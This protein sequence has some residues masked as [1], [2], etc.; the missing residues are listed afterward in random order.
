MSGWGHGGGVYEVEVRDERWAEGYIQKSCLTLCWLYC[1]WH[2]F[3]KRM[4]L[5]IPAYL[6]S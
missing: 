4:Y 3:S 1:T 2:T 5:A 6:C